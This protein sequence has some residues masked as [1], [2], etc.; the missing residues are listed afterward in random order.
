MEIQHIDINYG[1]KKVLMNVVVNVPSLY[2]L[3]V[4]SFYRRQFKRYLRMHRIPNVQQ[5]GEKEYLSQ[6]GGYFGKIEPYSYR[7]FTRYTDSANIAP[8][9]IGRCF[10]ETKLNPVAMRPVYE[11]KNMFPYS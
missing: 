1:T 9:N 7:L 3:Q 6:T 8:E 2:N 5:E 11:D 4:Y 10:L